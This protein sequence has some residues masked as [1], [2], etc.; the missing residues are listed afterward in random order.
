MTR[1]TVVWHAAA[2]DQLLRLWVAAT[3]RQ[4]IANAADAIDRELARD[5]AT[6]GVFAEDDF[7]EL[8]VAPLRVLFAVSEPDRLVR[9]TN[10]AID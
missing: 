7:R 1:Y 2:E 8:S 5:A 4:P 3:D 10:V 9:V 6:K